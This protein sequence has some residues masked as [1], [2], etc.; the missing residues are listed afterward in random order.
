MFIIDFYNINYTIDL[1]IHIY[2]NIDGLNINLYLITFIICTNLVII[3]II[4]IVATFVIALAIAII[5]IAIIDSAGI[6]TSF[7]G[8]SFNIFYLFR[9]TKVGCF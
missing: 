2:Y 7:K 9:D 1:T 6:F 5:V 3:I 4:L 8:I